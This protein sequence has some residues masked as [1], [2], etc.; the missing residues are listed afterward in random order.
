MM[1]LFN[2]IMK[3][4]R[5][6]QK[7]LPPAAMTFQALESQEL[8]VPNSPMREM[9]LEVIK[10][11]AAKKDKIITEGFTDAKLKQYFK[12][13]FKRIIAENCS[14][15]IIV[16]VHLN[17]TDDMFETFHTIFDGVCKAYGIKTNWPL[18]NT[19]HFTIDRRSFMD[20]VG[21]FQ[22]EPIDVEE[23]IRNMLHTGAVY[24]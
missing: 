1:W 18:P 14:S 21:K 13:V 3:L 2:W 12:L 16:P 11:E 9:F 20:A 23:K 4:F 24:R 7:L 17:L 19:T 6:E 10:E 5:K 15:V 8:M 22:E